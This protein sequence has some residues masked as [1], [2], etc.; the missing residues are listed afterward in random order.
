M[1]SSLVVSNPFNDAADD[2]IAGHSGLRAQLHHILPR[3]TYFHVHVLIHQVTNVPLVSGDFGVRW[4]F[5]NVHSP[6][7]GLLDI[8]KLKS[9]SKKGKGKARE[10]QDDDADSNSQGSTA[11][12]SQEHLP[13][14][15]V[16]PLPHLLSP[17]VGSS[18]ASTHT[19][20]SSSSHAS[21]A[22]S[23]ILTPA[24]PA[25]IPTPAR[26]RGQTTY[27]PLKDHTATWDHPVSVVVRM[28]VERSSSAL[29]LSSPLKLVVTQREDPTAPTLPHSKAANTRLGAVYLDLAQYVNKGEVVRRYLLRES[30]TNALLKVLLLPCI[31]DI[32]IGLNY[33]LPDSS[34]FR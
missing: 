27:T 5:K 17:S 18:S 19:L 25:P 6:P 21:S 34:Q 10:D 28:D 30:K 29:L 26:P 11:A 32:Q 33:S 31:L 16:S 2:D 23:L 9:S 13:T 15:R 4:K 3:H 14:G 20:S 7:R 24:H 1:H 8:V 22:P 12:A